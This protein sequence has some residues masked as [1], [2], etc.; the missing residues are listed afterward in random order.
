MGARGSNHPVFDATPQGPATEQEQI[1]GKTLAFDAGAKLSNDAV[2]A[3]SVPCPYEAMECSHL[4]RATN[5]L[6]LVATDQAGV[7]LVR[8]LGQLCKARYLGWRWRCD[9]DFQF[10]AVEE[11]LQRTGATAQF[12]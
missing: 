12:G 6:L 7:E 3:E 9:R 10:Q 8:A 5:H 2:I 1:H 4:V 11:R